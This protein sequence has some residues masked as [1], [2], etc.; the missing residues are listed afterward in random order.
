MCTGKCSFDRIDEPNFLLVKG[1]GDL[2]IP[3]IANYYI[4]SVVTKLVSTDL[5]E[6]RCVAFHDIPIISER[7]L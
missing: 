6:Y 4:F 2:P 3:Y 1:D 7:I 5:I